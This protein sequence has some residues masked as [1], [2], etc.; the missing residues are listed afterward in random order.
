MPTTRRNKS[1]D[2]AAD[3]T[4]EE[5]PLILLDD[6]QLDQ[7]AKDVLDARITP[8]TR[9]GYERDLVRFMLWAFDNS[10]KYGDM[11][12]P[13]TLEALKA[14]HQKDKERRTATGKP[15]K[16]R[17]HIRNKCYEFLRAIVKGDESTFPIKLE[18]INFAKYSRFL[19]TFRKV[20]KGKDSND[21]GKVI[22]RLRLSSFEAHCSAL[23][24]LFTECDKDRDATCP[25]LFNEL[26]KYKKGTRR[27]SAKERKKHGL[28][29]T[30]GKKHLPFKGYVRLAEILFK[31]ENK[32]YVQAH[33]FLVLDWN[34]MS[35]SESVIESNIDLI[36]QQ[37]D[38]INID[39]GKTKCDQEGL[40]YV[41]YPLHLYSNPREPC[42]CPVLA[43]CRLLICHPMILQGQSP[44][45]EGVAQYD[46]FH[47]IFKEIVSSDEYRDEFVALGIS[48][49]DFG[50]HSIRKGSATLCA[51]GCIV[52]PPISSICLR[53]C[54]ALPG[55]LNRYIKIA[56]AGDQ[57]VG[58]VVCGRDRMSVDF[59][60]SLPYFDFS[61]SV[62]A[63]YV[64]RHATVNAWIKDRMPVDARSNEGVFSLFKACIA[65]LAYHKK[66]GNLD[67]MHSNC[68][69][70]SSVFWM[71]D[72]PYADNVT[73]KYPWNKTRDTPEFTGLPPDVNLLVE[74]QTLKEEL[75]QMKEELKTSFKE[76]LVNELDT[77]NVG[78]ANHTQSNIILDKLDALLEK[79]DKICDARPSVSTC[80]P[81][82]D[83]NDEEFNSDDFVVE[84]EFDNQDPALE[85]IDAAAV[86]PLIKDALARKQR[87]ELMKKRS[88]KMGV[89]STGKI[90]PLPPGF[91]FPK[92]NMH[93]L[94][95]KW[96]IGDKQS[97][98]PPFRILHAN[99][100]FVSHV[101]NGKK[102]I[103]KMGKVMHQV[104]LLG[105][106][107]SAWQLDGRWDGGK[108]ETLYSKVYPLLDQYLRTE[109]KHGDKSTAKSRREQASWRTC[110]N[111]MGEQGLLGDRTRKAKKTDNAPKAVKKR[112]KDASANSQ[113]QKKRMK[114]HLV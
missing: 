75:A 94:I 23:A 20:V 59:T 15:C 25:G 113:L 114:E 106:S 66:N 107:Q 82:D 34:M 87:D 54:W 71:E 3:D 55:V 76:V 14:A 32:E 93:G 88:Y 13:S 81:F 6:G 74:V 19:G 104:M 40:K 33:T 108:V 90:T 111:K 103:S 102:I 83:D 1:N 77:R 5:P 11:F 101:E 109:G 49:E 91:T 62:G 22:V 12:T 21:G 73:T 100:N 18:N 47:A 31:S 79:A 110:Y 10:D 86:T 51:T 43:L 105:K 45:F 48:P 53:A 60:E 39:L 99:P 37:K 9:K 41:D 35:R 70:R 68:L 8:G 24:Y 112:K 61:D 29:T 78:G 16:M 98:I 89:S 30:E 38:S 58:K 84:Y 65:S 63:E 69:V 36:S 46:R 67:S 44:L 96:L 85:G 28:K 97:N 57:H 26:S 17:D 72:I 42:I 2:V 92:M 7:D 80:R 64:A 56:D 4:T 52:A 95:T 27:M 50:T